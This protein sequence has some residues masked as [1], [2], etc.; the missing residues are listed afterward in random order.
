MQHPT[1][2]PGWASSGLGADTEREGLLFF[3]SDVF[4]AWMGKGCH[5]TEGTTYLWFQLGKW[6]RSQLCGP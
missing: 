6:L 2:C 1:L 3:H 4:D 5:V